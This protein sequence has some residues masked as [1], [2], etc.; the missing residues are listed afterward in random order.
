M[1]H[2]AVMAFKPQVLGVH[3]G[4]LL[5]SAM[6]VITGF[7]LAFAWEWQITLLITAFAP[8]TV[9]GSLLQ[10]KV[11]IWAEQSHSQCM[12]E[13]NEVRRQCLVLPVRE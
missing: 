9:L 10:G 4:A 1:N 8:L 7:S 6:T 12:A 5:E 13:A 11:Q 3:T 2:K